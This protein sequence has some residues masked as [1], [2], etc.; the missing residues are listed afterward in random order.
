MNFAS[1]TIMP[2]LARLII[3][4][5]MLT[6][7][8]LNCFGQV[9]IREVVAH[10]LQEM[11]ISVHFPADSEPNVSEAGEAEGVPT[12]DEGTEQLTPISPSTSPTT[13]GVHR[14]TWLLH[15]KWPTLGGWGPFIA[16]SAAIAQL[17]GGI[18]ILVGLYT[19]FA[20]LCIA[21]V[22]G[23]A[24]YLVSQHIHGMFTMNPFDWPLDSHRFIQLFAG[25]ALG[26]LALGLVFGG[27]GGLSIDHRH[28]AGVPQDKKQ[29]SEK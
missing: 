27:A 11:K 2:L 5:A 6:S 26:T 25:L 4:S 7:G 21:V 15:S 24:V 17:L 18:L 22:L 19:R 12:G 23:V 1:S 3:A 20:S 8:W 28:R 13:K 29:P 9:Q 14:I 16:W 10:G